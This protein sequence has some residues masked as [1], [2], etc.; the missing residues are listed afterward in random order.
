MTEE[1]N[2]SQKEDINP[3]A[4]EKDKKQWRLNA[5]ILAG[6]ILL[7]AV[8]PPEYKVFAPVLFLI[9]VI[10]SVVNKIRQFGDNSGNATQDQTYSPPVYE[11]TSALEPYS[12]EPKDPKDPR[13]YK[14]IG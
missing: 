13:R 11:D 5:L 2:S 8:L 4:S 12:Y 6:V 1:M 10:V 3:K 9:P 7:S 14:P